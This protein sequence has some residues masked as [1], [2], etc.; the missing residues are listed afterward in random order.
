MES[1]SFDQGWREIKKE[2]HH[3]S[4]IY[5]RTS[6]IKGQ[7]A[8]H[9]FHALYHMLNVF[10]VWCLSWIKCHVALTFYML[11]NMCKLC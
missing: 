8:P 9:T 3:M 6:W 7:V 5:N 4:P 11:C 2:F 1:P 10:N